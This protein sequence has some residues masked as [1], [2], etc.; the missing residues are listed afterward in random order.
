MQQLCL[1]RFNLLGREFD[2]SY[3]RFTPLSSYPGMSTG[4][5]GIAQYRIGHGMDAKRWTEKFFFKT[6]LL[7]GKIKLLCGRQR[8]VRQCLFGKMFD[9]LSSKKKR[10]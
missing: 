5:I 10:S 8:L 4:A 2:R 3:D 7:I 1:K 6:N 9:S